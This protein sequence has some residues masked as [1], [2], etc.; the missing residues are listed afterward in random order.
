MRCS[1]TSRSDTTDAAG[2]AP[3]V[4][5]RR[6][7]FRMKNE[8]VAYKDSSGLTSSNPGH[9]EPPLQTGRDTPVSA[10]PPPERARPAAVARSLLA[11]HGLLRFHHHVRS[12]DSAVRA[13][14][15]RE[16]PAHGGDVGGR[17]ATVLLRVPVPSQV[18]S[19]LLERQPGSARSAHATS[20]VRQRFLV[21]G[22]SVSLIRHGSQSVGDHRHN[23]S[24]GREGSPLAVAPRAVAD[25]V[26]LV[27]GCPP[28]RLPPVGRRVGRRPIPK[29]REAPF[30]RPRQPAR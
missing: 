2:T 25:G 22:P 14:P 29:G 13:A 18:R 17:N 15:G 8:I 1:R 3:S 6:Q 7:S 10:V 19:D 16:L 23:A 30:R 12:G 4:G 5:S 28:I 11:V 20:H 9:P 21:A 27:G 26:R 24:T